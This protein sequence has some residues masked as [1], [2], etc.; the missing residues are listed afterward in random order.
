[1]KNTKEAQQYLDL[2]LR[3]LQRNHKVRKTLQYVALCAVLATGIYFASGL[4]PHHYSLRISG[5]ELLGDRQIVAKMME[6]Q[7]VEYGVDLSITPLEGSVEAIQAVSKGEVDLA[8][9][10]N[11]L[12]VDLPNI[13]HV[14][15]LPPEAMHVLVKPGINSIQDFKDKRINLG[16][17]TGGIRIISKQVL[18]FSNLKSDIDYIETNYHFEDLVSMT[19]ENLPEVVV[20]LAYTPSYMAD[21]FVN[22][23]GYRIMELPFPE[24]LSLRQGWASDTKILA[25]TYHTLPAVPEKDI[26]TVGVN[27]QLIANADV[28]PNAIKMVLESMYNPSFENTLHQ[29]MDEESMTDSA[30]YPISPGTKEFLT[31]NESFFSSKTVDKIQDSFGVVM[32]FVSTIIII[33]KWFKGEEPE[34]EVTRDQ[35]FM[36]Y[37]NQVNEIEKEIEGMG[38]R[39]EFLA[40]DLLRISHRLTVLKRRV[41][42]EYHNGARLNDPGIMDRFLTSIS[43]TRNYVSLLIGQQN[44]KNGK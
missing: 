44:L 39:G 41:L 31:R 32:T 30:Y 8:L 3:K 20:N 6:E 18:E 37:L 10:Q 19:D 42:E 17:K 34:K 40:E 11:G 35:E 7:A 2:F 9:I 14:A 27:L 13:H 15:T 1:M 28:D 21:Y 43:D 38:E 23:R 29:K 5:G 33:L 25:Y 22:K 36:G 4:I 12:N 24:S 16:L 26:R